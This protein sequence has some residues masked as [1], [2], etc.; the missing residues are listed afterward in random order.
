MKMYKCIIYLNVFE[1][2]VYRNFLFFFYRIWS[3]LFV[4]ISVMKLS[5]FY[6]DFLVCC[7]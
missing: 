1:V 2:K 3:R 4:E 6:L 5:L 7:C